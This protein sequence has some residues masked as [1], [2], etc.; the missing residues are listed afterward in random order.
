MPVGPVND[1]AVTRN[2]DVGDR[3]QGVISHGA[4]S[5]RFVVDQTWYDSPETAPKSI[6]HPGGTDRRAVQ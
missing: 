2:A 6:A 3:A 4:L 5:G 1:A